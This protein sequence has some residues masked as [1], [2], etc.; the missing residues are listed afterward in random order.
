M[1]KKPID[2]VLEKNK[3]RESKTSDK[4]SRMLADR[5]L[6]EIK[7]FE[8]D[9]VSLAKQSAK[10]AWMVATGFGVLA[11]LSILAVVGLTPLKE[12]EPFLV[13]VDNSTGHTDIMRPLADAQSLTYG[14]VLDSYWLRIYTTER[15]S[16]DWENVQNSYNTVKLMSNNN[17]FGEYSRMIKSENSPVKTFT[18]TRKI[19]V[20]VSD[21]SFLPAISKDSTLA[22]IRFKRDVR[23]SDGKPVTGY[24]TTLWTATITF[25]YLAVINTDAERQLNPLGFRVTSYR[26]DRVSQR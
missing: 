19:V 14:E 17:V 18:D 16:Y 26:E 6:Q 9:R 13:R 7:A 21:I 5:Y 1:T 10:K 24:K 22:Q 23:T 11:L 4:K 15:N 3:D 8:Q 12:V 25:D 20:S 2:N